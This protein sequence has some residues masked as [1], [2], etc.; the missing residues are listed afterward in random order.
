MTAEQ[1]AACMTSGA[2][3]RLEPMPK[4]SP[5]TMK[6]PLLD[7]LVEAGTQV[8]HQVRRQVL[9]VQALELPLAR[10][11][12]VGVDV[13]AEN[14][15]VAGQLLHQSTSLGSAMLPLIAEYAAVAGDAR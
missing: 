3:S 1:P 10:D 11:D 9:H 13:L 8:L 4:F 14:V 2:C 15:R 6:S 5:A 7:L 12:V